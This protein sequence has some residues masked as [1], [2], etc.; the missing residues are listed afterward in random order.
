MSY[1]QLTLEK[2]YHIS[3]LQKAGLN[4]KEIAIKLSV[5][6]STI[7]RES[8]RNIDDVRGYNPELAHIKSSKKHKEK[9]KRESISKRVEKYIRAKLKQ[10]WS[11]EQIAGRMKLDTGIL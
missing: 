8:R 1:S 3:A 5:H 7:S 10:D 4:Q 11:P 2:R 9:S 6:P